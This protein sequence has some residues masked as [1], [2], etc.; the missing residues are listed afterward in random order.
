M[1]PSTQHVAV[2]PLGPAVA[3]TV[4]WLQRGRLH[5]TVV[6][7]ATFAL[8]PEGRMSVVAPDPIAPEEQRDPSG[9]WLQAAGDLAPYLDSCGVV[10]TGHAELP[11]QVDGLEHELRVTRFEG[12]EGISELF[13]FDV[14]VASSEKDI[15]LT[16]VVGKTALLTWQ[17]GEQPR[18]L[19]GVVASFEQDEEGKRLTAY[20]ATVVPD[21]ARLKHRRNSRIFQALSTPEII[22]KELR[23]AGIPSN[24]YRSLLSGVYRARE[25]CVQYR[26]SDF[27]FLSRLM[28][29]EGISYYFEHDEGGH[30][31]VFADSPSAHASIAGEST[32]VFR[33]QLGA[34]VQGE[35]VSRFRYTERVRSGK[36][37]SRA[38]PW[39]DRARRAS[40][41]ASPRAWTRAT[42]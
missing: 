18:F 3:A 26:E 14:P 9:Q 30:V 42:R 36:V 13:H 10:A 40:P 27:A 7:K 32:L 41:R 37:T 35:H 34:L 17:V 19:H 39:G 11:F 6:V 25:Y 31:L 29:E 15:T 33:P 23:A 4:T 5:V 22:E 16:D 21:V 38:S 24:G 2:T 8:V 12:R 28:E 1:I 20:H